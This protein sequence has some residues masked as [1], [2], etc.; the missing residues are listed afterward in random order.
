MQL[1]REGGILSFPFIPITGAVRSG[2]AISWRG[3][4]DAEKE[5]DTSSA[6]SGALSS[7]AAQC[8]THLI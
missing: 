8:V 1:L 5:D 3:K 7:A 4:T 2:I 6:A